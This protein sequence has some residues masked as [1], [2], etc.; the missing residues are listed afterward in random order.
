[1]SLHI[2]GLSSAVQEHYL[3]RVFQKF[4]PCT[5]RRMKDRYGFAV[6]DASGDAARAL[7]QLHGTFV[8]GRRITVNWSK[9]QPNHSRSFRRSSR[10]IGSSNGRASRDG[11]DNFRLSEPAAQKSDPV[12]GV[13]EKNNH[14]SH[15]KSHNPDDIVEKNSDEIAEGMKEA[16]ESIGE[17]PGEMKMDDGGTSD[18]RENNGE[19]PVEM[20]MDDGGTSGANAIE[21]DRWGET[22]IGNHGGDDDD[23]DRFEPY[24]GY[25]KR[26]EKKKTV[27]AEHRRISE[28]WQKHPAERF[29][30]NHGK[31]RALPTC[32]K[33]LGDGFSL[34]ERE[35]L[36]LRE[37]RYPSTRRPESHVDPMT[38]AHH[39]VQDFR[40][41][42][43][44]RTGRA[45][46]LSDVPRL[47][48]THIPQSENMAEAPKEAHNGSKLKRSREPSLSSERNSSCSRSRS[49]CPRSRAQSPSHS[50]HSSS[51]SSQPTQ[52][53]GLKLGPRSNLS[54]H[55]PL[56]VSVSPKCDSPPAAARSELR[57][58]D[59]CKQEAEG[60]R[61]NCEI[62]AASSKLGAQ[63]NGDLPVPGVDVKVSG[64]A[65]TN[66]HKDMVDDIVGDALLGE[67][68]NPED[69]L[70][71]KS[72]M[73]HVVK[74]GRII[75]LKLTTSE[76]VS[77][78]KHYGVETREVVLSN[79]TVENYFGAARLWPWEIIYYRRSKKGPI[80]TENYGKRLEQNK[81]FGIVDQY[82][83]SSSGWWER[84]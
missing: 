15:D 66:L 46:K 61:L 8:C 7:R 36:R 34:R 6:F 55:G 81:E 26:E 11:V 74:K 76:V 67:T 77:A 44:D 58:M 65:E 24:H 13:E 54:H 50:A 19:D 56:S 3:Q 18:A 38:R 45:P 62:P 64:H 73:E 80:S 27:K 1:M 40:K 28:K 51:K 5:V 20:K 29:E 82:V 69:T 33:T 37:F 22:G 60:S 48:R 42:F 84:H 35:E 21:H 72:N 49:P 75:S 59:D 2:G 53:G 16:G 12:D 32:Y 17:D 52:H 79:Q 68:T 39:R 31:S 14:M 25:R 10:K 41:P 71:V 43:S 47:D 23:F 63:S 9:H 4:G 57:H 70:S 78:L 83:R 30:Q